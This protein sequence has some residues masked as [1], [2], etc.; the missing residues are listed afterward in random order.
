MDEVAEENLW[1]QGLFE[2][3]QRAQEEIVECCY[4]IC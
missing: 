3:T 4:L 1:Q 2:V